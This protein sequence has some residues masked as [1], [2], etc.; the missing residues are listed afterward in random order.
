MV[1]LLKD[2]P[3]C[4][5]VHQ[6]IGLTK[7]NEAHVQGLMKLPCL[8]HEGLQYVDLVVTATAFAETTLVLA[9]KKFNMWLQAIGNDLRYLRP[10]WEHSAVRSRDNCRS[11]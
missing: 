9:L 2:C 11:H 1:A 4:V 5:T 6:V 8:L 7:V 10:C 3:Q